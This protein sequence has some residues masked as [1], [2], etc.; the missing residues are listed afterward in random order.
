MVRWVL[1]ISGIPPARRT[2]F[3]PH[4][5]TGI[6]G[7]W[8]L[9]T[10]KP[11][12]FWIVFAFLIFAR[13]WPAVGQIRYDIVE[14]AE[15]KKTLLLRDFRPQPM[16]HTDVRNV[17]RAR[18]PVIDVHN[19]VNDAMGVNTDHLPAA[20]VV[21]VM[22]RCN[23]KT[24]CI[25]TGMWGEKLQRVI[26]EMVRPYPDRFMVF[27]QLDWSKFDDPDFGQQM[28]RQIDD[29]VKRG[30]K[31]LKVM[32]DLGLEVRDKSGRLVPVDD[33]RLD[34]IWEECGRVGMPVAIHSADPEAFFRPVNETNEQYEELIG[35]PSWQFSDPK[36]F[37][38]L[39]QILEAQ[40]RMFAK[41]PNT[42]FIA[43][44][45][46]SWPE[47]L[48]YVSELLKQLPN[49]FV[50][51]G[52]REAELGRQPRRAARFFREY[53][54]RI[55]FGTDYTVTEEMYR[56]HFRWLETG[57]E[58]FEHWDYPSLGRWM[59]YGLELP[60]PILEKVYHQNAERIFSQF[61]GTRGRSGQ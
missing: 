42:T 17:L 44:H 19:H 9:P 51:F 34:P 26:D 52:A 24:I 61:K 32:K 25:L 27:T 50:E 22:D 56:N 4:A 36:R 41:H 28:V 57:D 53:Q 20:K 5:L 6:C 13:A 21:E 49:V 60:D 35:Q 33:P 11:K 2:C 15:E 23:I 40:K 55:L 38:S 8:G 1:S 16:L 48:D 18:F 30:A 54:D 39:P 10:L 29:A 37:P 46:A 31:G 45:V 12:G 47:N 43:L 3:R 59:I 58:Y 14:G 7:R